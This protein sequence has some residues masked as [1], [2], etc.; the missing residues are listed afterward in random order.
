MFGRDNGLFIVYSNGIGIDDDEV[1]TGNAMVID[2]YGRIIN[3]TCE[4]ADAM[5]VADMDMGLLSQCT[6]RRWMRARR[7][8]LYGPVTEVTGRELDARTARFT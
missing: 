5:V 8:D 4:A 1:R 7:P 6:G 3:E 2:C